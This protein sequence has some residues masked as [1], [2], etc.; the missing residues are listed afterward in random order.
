M[1][2]PAARQVWNR[3]DY[4]A[5]EQSA[6]VVVLSREADIGTN[7]LDAHKRLYCMVV[8]D[9]PYFRISLRLS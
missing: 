9:F 1:E 5:A 6:V 4:T 3:L 8:I 7:N 2:E